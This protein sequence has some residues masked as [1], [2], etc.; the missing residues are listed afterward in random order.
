MIQKLPLPSPCKDYWLGPL[1][2]GKF[3]LSFILSFITFGFEIT[4]PRGNCNHLPPGDYA[5]I[6]SRTAELGSGC[7]LVIYYLTV[8]INYHAFKSKL[9]F[10]YHL[11]R[12]IADKYPNSANTYSALDL[13]DWS[14]SV[15][16]TAYRKSNPICLWFETTLMW[17]NRLA[18]E[19][20]CYHLKVFIQISQIETRFIQK[21]FLSVI[22]KY[23]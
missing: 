17:A 12:K 13:R 14:S 23:Q 1:P 4:H 19:T 7:D 15:L 5:W 8:F 16:M 6:F 10:C 11:L 3:W 9:N 22:R 18:G 20:T 21:Y 2:L